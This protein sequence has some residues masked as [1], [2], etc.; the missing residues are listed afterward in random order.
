M[1]KEQ[2]NNNLTIKNQELDVKN[3]ELDEALHNLE[4]KSNE[5]A[6]TLLELTNFKLTYDK[7]QHDF[8]REVIDSQNFLQPMQSS[9]D[10]ERKM[11]AQSARHDALNEIENLRAAGLPEND[12]FKTLSDDEFSKYQERLSKYKT[13]IANLSDKNFDIVACT[14]DFLIAPWISTIRMSLRRLDE[15]LDITRDVYTVAEV[16]EHLTTA[17]AIPKALLEGKANAVIKI[18]VENNMN[19]DARLN[20]VMSKLESVVFNLISNSTQAIS[21][22]KQKLRK[23]KSELRK[24]YKGAVKLHIYQTQ[25]REKPCLCIEVSDNAGGFSEEILKDIYKKPVLSSKEAGRTG[26][27]TSYI[28]YFVK[29][30]DGETEADNIILDD[31]SK[32]ARTRVYIFCEGQ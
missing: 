7:I 1:R 24:T 6:A 14:Y 19:S 9:W 29:L 12:R 23:E 2:V 3:R 10:K 32:G 26:E 13:A 5:Q 18:D 22:Y 4:K 20:I 15:I 8:K 21:N 17:K 30:M 16:V 11:A 31:G 25:R 27:G 28:G